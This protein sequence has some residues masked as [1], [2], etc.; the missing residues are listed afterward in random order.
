MGF[1]RK[2]RRR[3]GSKQFA[4]SNLFSIFFPFF[5]HHS[6]GFILSMRLSLGRNCTFWRVIVAKL[7]GQPVRRTHRG[8]GWVYV[9]TVGRR[10]LR[11]VGGTFCSCSFLVLIRSLL[12][13]H[14][15]PSTWEVT[16]ILS[17][18]FISR[19]AVE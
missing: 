16:V 6:F 17:C 13:Q 14:L 18:E 8:Q 9:L 7:C 10:G 12:P 4:S 19:L 15:H 11:G 5:F 2:T 3:Q 1:K